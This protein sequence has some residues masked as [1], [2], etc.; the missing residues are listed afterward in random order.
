MYS[1]KT[2]FLESTFVQKKGRSTVKGH[3]DAWTT[4]RDLKALLI[5]EDKS[6]FE[7]VIVSP[8]NSNVVGAM[9]YPVTVTIGLIVTLRRRESNLPLET[10]DQV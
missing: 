7:L 9:G 5:E 2:V 3:V 4:S 10:K 6:G 1:Y 8:V